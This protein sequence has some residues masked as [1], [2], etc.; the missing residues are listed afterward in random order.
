MSLFTIFHA[1]SSNIGEVFSIN[2]SANVFVFGDFN[3]NHNDGLTYSVGT[4]SPGELSQ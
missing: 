3:V 1:I 2:S 4:D